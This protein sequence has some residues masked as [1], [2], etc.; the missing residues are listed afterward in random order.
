MDLHSRI[1]DFHTYEVSPVQ[2]WFAFLDVGFLPG[3]AGIV[4]ATGPHPDC[5]ETGSRRRGLHQGS[6]GDEG[7]QS[8]DVLD[9][10]ETLST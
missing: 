5:V 8:F 1:V 2:F 3:D 10:A 7:L 9:A 4:V 6:A